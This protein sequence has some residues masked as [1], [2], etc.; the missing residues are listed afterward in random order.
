[1]LNCDKNNWAFASGD[2][3]SPRSA[4]LWLILWSR[5]GELKTMNKY[6][7][8]DIGGTEIKYSV[9]DQNLNFMDRGIRKTPYENGIDGFLDTILDIYRPYQQKVEGIAVSMPGVIDSVRGYCYTGGS[10]LYNAE[11]PIAELITK[12]CNTRVHIENDGKCAALAEYWRGELQGCSNGLVMILGTGIGGG[13]IIDGKLLRGQH[14]FAGELSYLNINM[15]KWEEA[16]S[17]FAVKYGAVP[18]I[19][20]IK[21][22]KGIEDDGFD[23]VRAFELINAGDEQALEVFHQFARGIAL[24]LCNLQVILDM[25]VVAIGGG[26]SRQDIV[27]ET[28]KKCWDEII[29]NHPAKNYATTL[30]QADLKRCK[31]TSNAN[32]VGALYS[33]LEFYSESF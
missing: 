7:V 23:G 29:D 19:R 16:D 32:L 22:I 13:I 21:E 4:F 27:V 8:I 15:D 2:G 24:Q 33:Y 3:K 9:M 25:E 28:I 26:I 5:K 10:L 18:M 14:F 1:M 30:P 20:K 6:L 17:C 31:F 11:Q 12:K